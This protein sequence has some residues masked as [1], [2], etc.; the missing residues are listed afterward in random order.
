MS[1]QSDFILSFAIPSVII[2]VGFGCALF[3]MLCKK[4][5]PVSKSEHVTILC[6]SPHITVNIVYTQEK[7][8]PIVDCSDPV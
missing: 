4:P 5:T 7:V 2:V 8:K 6:D 3:E 1:T